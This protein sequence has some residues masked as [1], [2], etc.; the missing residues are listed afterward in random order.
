M[1]DLGW[2]HFGLETVFDLQMT[3]GCPPLRLLYAP[4]TSPPASYSYNPSPCAQFQYHFW[5][6][7]SFVRQH[8]QVLRRFLRKIKRLIKSRQI[9]PL[10]LKLT[11][12]QY[13]GWPPQPSKLYRYLLVECFQ[14]KAGHMLL[15]ATNL[16]CNQLAW[17][18]RSGTRQSISLCLLKL[19]K[20][21]C[22]IFPCNQYS[23]QN[24]CK[25]S[26]SV[27]LL[28]WLLLWYLI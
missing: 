12:R 26:T 10:K 22:C 8:P 11:S 28:S 2:I 20:R 19:T 3:S 14:Q 21:F 1:L 13:L 15:S 23:P 4:K 16:L 5:P 25:C 9:I 18:K 24:V 6:L 7:H 17:R 27:S